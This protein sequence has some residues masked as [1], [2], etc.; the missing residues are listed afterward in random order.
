[1]TP[2]SIYEEFGVEPIINAVGW[3]TRLGGHVMD[4]V[5]VAGMAE[6]AK[7]SVDMTEL[8]AAASRVISDATGA[9]AGLV[10]SGAAAGLLLA[11]AACVTGADPSKMARLPDT[12]GMRN[13]VIVPRSHRNLYDHAVRTAGVTLIE[14]GVPDR[15]S[16]AGSRD[17]EPWEIEAALTANT[18]AILYVATPWARP[19]LEQVIES[20]H[21][22]GVPIII[23]AAAQ[24]PPSSNLRSFIAAGADLVAFSGGKAIGG[25]QSSG[26]LCGRRD[27]IEAAALQML[28]LDVVDELWSPPSRFI[29]R[30]GIAGVP[31]HGIGRPC[32]VGKEEIIGLLVALRR[33]QK[34]DEKGSVEFWNG[35]THDLRRRIEGIVACKLQVSTSERGADVLD[36]V[37][38]GGD[39]F[40]RAT[41]LARRLQ[42]GRP[43][44]VAD[45]S[46]LHEGAIRFAP[47][48]LKEA[49]VEIIAERLLDAAS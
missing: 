38:S 33:F 21:K 17:C 8:Q 32:K 26:I 44:I 47:Y 4:D 23:D 42:M 24:L 10:T 27:L 45:L 43:A 41:A 29:D 19:S 11:T 18:A 39:A 46:R 22:H 48:C 37:F 25:P 31:P 3:A 13:E 49:D 1:M 34:R 15:F 6:A 16:G 5:V 7:H 14:V 35:L 2:K 20:G 9:E 36:V 40:A 30:A 12:R 28:D